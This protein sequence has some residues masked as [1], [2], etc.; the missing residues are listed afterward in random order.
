MWTC[1][2]G[3]VYLQV[4]CGWGK[5]LRPVDLRELRAGDHL[6]THQ[7]LHAIVVHPVTQQR[8]ASTHNTSL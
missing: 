2:E 5:D 6:P 8:V 4:P 1:V 7:V 3:R